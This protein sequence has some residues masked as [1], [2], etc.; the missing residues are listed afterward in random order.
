[1]GKL[2]LEGG[3]AGSLLATGWFQPGANNFLETFTTSDGVTPRKDLNGNGGSYI[4][5]SNSPTNLEASKQLERDAREIWV[6][7]AVSIPTFGFTSA[8][9]HF[10]LDDSSGSSQTNIFQPGNASFVRARRDAATLGDSAIGTVPES[11]DF[12]ILSVR[13]YIDNAAGEVEVFKDFNFGS[14]LLSLTG[15]DTQ[16]GSDNFAR[17]LRVQADDS[18]YDDLSATDATVVFDTTADTLLVGATITGNNSG[19]TA[20]VTAIVSGSGAGQGVAQVHFVRVNGT[21]AWNDPSI[22]P[23]ATDTVLSDGVLW[24]ANVLAPRTTFKDDNSGPASDG[25]IFA[26]LPTTDVAGKIQL[27]RAG[28]DTGSNAGQVAAIPADDVTALQSGV[29]TNIPGQRD[30]Y[31]LQDTTAVGFSGSDITAVTSVMVSAYWQRDGAGLNNGN[32]I[33]EDLGV[34]YDGPDFSLSVAGNGDGRLLNA[35]P[36]ASVSGI[37]WSEAKINSLRAGIKLKG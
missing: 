8:P 27:T 32:I 36:D 18:Y 24:T 19:T 6:R 4:F 25:L 11:T 33:V 1:M 21:D 20:I 10:S 26:L 17:F 37:T 16:N 29:Q 30:V 2:L 28:I 15:I 13:V 5:G 34:E 7:I 35:V 12:I 23:W 22:D 31:E 3:E 9:T 14:P